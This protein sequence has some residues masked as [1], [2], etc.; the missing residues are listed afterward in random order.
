M[1]PGEHKIEINPYENI[2]EEIYITE[3]EH[4]SPAILT[5]ILK[6]EGGAAGL[7]A[8][9]KALNAAE[10]DIIDAL[11]EMPNVGKHEDGDYILEDGVEIIV[12]ESVPNDELASLEEKK[13]KRKKKTK[14]SR[15][16]IIKRILT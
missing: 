9:T 12:N 11:E 3:D 8:F 14:E 15:I 16:R 4:I 5:Q 13:K 2:L 10:Q 6:D 7:E 1:R